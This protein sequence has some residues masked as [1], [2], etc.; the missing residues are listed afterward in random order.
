MDS[1]NMIGRL[2]HGWT[3][4]AN[5][6][7]YEDLLRNNVLPGI[8]AK[9]VAGYRGARLLRRDNGPDE[10]EFLT[11]L[12][13]ESLDAVKQFAGADYEHAYVPAAARELLS[14]FDERSQHYEIRIGEEETLP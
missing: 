14:R 12:S 6:D 5:A 7:A 8:A 9:D 3:T 4:R 10:V 13:F 1:Q 11:L 2:W